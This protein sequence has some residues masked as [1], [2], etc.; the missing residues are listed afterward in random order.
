MFSKHALQPSS[1]Q[2]Q[3]TFGFR[4][5][6]CLWKGRMLHLIPNDVMCGF[7]SKTPLGLAQ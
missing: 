2:Q 4:A 6:I 5:V 7:I 3:Y 1:R